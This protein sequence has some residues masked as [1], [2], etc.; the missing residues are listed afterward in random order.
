MTNETFK[1]CRS[2]KVIESLSTF[3]FNVMY[4]ITI[5]KVQ[6][7]AH[8]CKDIASKVYKKS[9]EIQRVHNGYSCILRIC[10][11]RIREA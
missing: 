2:S 9:N 4:G 5:I 6:K 11:K 7:Y 3:L 1:R 10:C 8:P